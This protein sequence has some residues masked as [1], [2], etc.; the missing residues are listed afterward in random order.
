VTQAEFNGTVENSVFDF[1]SAKA[2]PLP[3]MKALILEVTRNQKAVEEMQKQYTCH[4][5]SEEEKVDSKGKVASKTVKEFEVFY[6]AG[7]EVRRLVKKDG[8][9]LAGDEKKKEDERFNKQ[10]E[11]LQKQAEELARDPRKQQKQAEKEEAT[12]SDILRVVRFSNARRE[13]FRGQDVIAVDFGPNP[14][15]K[16]KKAIESVVQKTS[17]VVWIDEQARDV[18]R[19]EAHFT[20]TAKIG[21]GLLAALD[22]GSSLVFEQAKVNDEVWLPSYTEIHATGRFLVVKVRENG[23]ERYTDYRKF[24]AESKIVSVKE[25]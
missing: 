7:D 24:S 2:A 17:G 6:L 11:K 20:D 23:V 16:P 18:A 5:I 4:L 8:K 10:Y 21:M 1:P 12:I 19:V 9:E 25:K 13:R 14:E 22:K 15:Y 3:D